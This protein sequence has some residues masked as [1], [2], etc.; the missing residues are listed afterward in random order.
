MIFIRKIMAMAHNVK[1]T[2][3][4][5]DIIHGGYANILKMNVMM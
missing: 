3:V 1:K 5:H 4:D 2:S